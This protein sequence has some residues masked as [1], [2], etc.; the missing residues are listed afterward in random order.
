MITLVERVDHERW[1]DSNNVVVR[2]PG[3]PD[4]VLYG[5]EYDF[6]M[7]G[8]II[9]AKKKEWSPSLRNAFMGSAT[10]YPHLTTPSSILN[11]AGVL[12]QRKRE[13]RKWMQ[14]TETQP[15][16]LIQCIQKNN[17]DI[18]CAEVNAEV[19]RYEIIEAMK[20]H[21]CVWIDAS[22]TKN[23]SMIKDTSGLKMLVQKGEIVRRNH[24]ITMQWAYKQ[25]CNLIETQEY[26]DCADAPPSEDLT[27]ARG[28]LSRRV[29]AFIDREIVCNTMLRFERKWIVSESAWKLNPKLTEIISR[30]KLTEWIKKAEME[31]SILIS[32]E[33]MFTTALDG[34]GKAVHARPNVEKREFITINN[35]FQISNVAAQTELRSVCVRQFKDIFRIPIDAEFKT[36][37][38]V[39]DNTVD[40]SWIREASLRATNV[41]ILHLV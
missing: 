37:Y 33:I 29:D 36:A 16:R 35:K 18:Q 8:R 28:D 7:D 30:H 17:G 38:V 25:I 6:A 20:R 21:R 3:E 13:L 9:R 4:L 23:G 1:R 10:S 11:H 26:V 41:V 34:T 27:C 19:W 14:F 12:P 2:V 15:D 40:E 32:N 31:G 39:V 24:Q 5:V 22:Q